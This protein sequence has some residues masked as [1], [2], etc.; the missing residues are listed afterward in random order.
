MQCKGGGGGG[1][2]SNKHRQQDRFGNRKPEGVSP[3][4]TES[5]P[6]Y[7]CSKKEEESE[8]ARLERANQLKHLQLPSHF[9]MQLYPNYTQKHVITYTNQC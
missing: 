1:Y 3:A 8:L 9:L 7:H 6:L 4:T 5:L 2:R